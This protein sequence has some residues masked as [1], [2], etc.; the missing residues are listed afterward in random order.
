M[1]IRQQ[2][3]NQGNI[4]LA[5]LLGVL[6]GPEER[7]KEQ[8]GELR[9]QNEESKRHFNELQEQLHSKLG[10]ENYRRCQ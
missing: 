10:D 9:K 4:S 7:M 2:A 5:D 1:E 6:R 3:S 8:K